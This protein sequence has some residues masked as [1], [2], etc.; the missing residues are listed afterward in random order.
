MDALVDKRRQATAA[1]IDRVKGILEDKPLSRELL[2][3]ALTALLDYADPD[4]FPLE[5]FPADEFGEDRTYKLWQDDDFR[6]ALYLS[7]SPDGVT[8]PPHNHLTWAAITVLSGEEINLLYQIA[9]H[10]KEPGQDPVRV[11]GRESVTPGKGLILMP[12][13]VHAIETVA[14]PDSGVA[15]LLHLYGHAIDRPTGR[16]MFDPVSGAARGYDD[17]MPALAPPMGA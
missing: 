13:D 5:H 10:P 8:T 14:D 9:H 6:Y 7:S 16:R 3:E 2:T 11:I 1:M 17:A 12:N 15:M 4:L